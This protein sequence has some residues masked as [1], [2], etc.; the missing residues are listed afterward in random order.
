MVLWGHLVSPLAIAQAPQQPQ[1]WA[2]VNAA[3]YVPDSALS[4]GVIFALFGSSLTNGG[5]AA[6][7][8]TPLPTTLAGASVIVNGLLA[9]LFFASPGQINAQFPVELTDVAEANIEVRV[10]TAGGSSTSIPL[11]VPVEPFSPGIF[12]L[13]RNGSGPGAILR[14]NDFT[15]ICPAGRVDCTV[16]YAAAGDVIAIYLTGLGPPEGEWRS[17]EASLPSAST[18]TT[19]IVTVGGLPVPVL[20]SGLVEGLVGLYQINASVPSNV[21]LLLGVPLEVSISSYTSNAVTLST[22]PTVTPPGV[23]RGG[24]PTGGLVWDIAI[25]PSNS[26]IL[27]AATN[28]GVFKSAKG[29]VHWSPVNIGGLGNRIVMQILLDHSN[30]ATLFAA[31]NGGGV[32]KSIDAGANW[33]PSNAGL[34]NNSA[35]AF[36]ESPSS[37]GALYVATGGGVFKSTDG[38]ESWSGASTGLT[39]TNVMFL[40]ADPINSAVLYAATSG[41][42]FKTI[43]GGA[44]WIRANT[45]IT[46]SFVACVAVDPSNPS[47]VYAATA[48][49]G[50]FKTTNGGVSWSP[51]NLGLADLRLS[52]LVVDPSRPATLLAGTAEEGVFRSGDGGGS[53]SPASNGLSIDAIFTLELGRVDPG[54]VFAGTSGG[55]FRTSDGGTSWSMLN[56]GLSASATKSLAVDQD[57]PSVVIAATDG[58]GVFKSTNGGA[59]WKSINR[60][61]GR[62]SGF[63]NALAL[64]PRNV[65]I[66]YAALSNA[67]VKSVDGGSNWTVAQTGL[68]SAFLI[69]SLVVDPSN[70]DIVY[71]GFVNGRGVYRSHNGAGTWEV[72]NQGLTNLNVVSLAIHPA[73]PSI[74]YAGTR[75]GIFRSA[76]AGA[77]WSLLSTGITP[78]ALAIDPTDPARIYAATGGSGV[79]KSVDGGATWSSA[80]SGLPAVSIVSSLVIDPATPTTIYAG[81]QSVNGSNGVYK[82]TNGGEDWSLIIGGMP[83]WPVLSLA[84]DPVNPATVLAGTSG[85]GVY[86]TLDGGLLWQP[87]SPF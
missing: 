18:Q 24:G 27:Y 43:D 2:A 81:L 54:V 61:L 34:L 48:R 23:L 25:D 82:S 76:S 47:V 62:V 49:N 5:T 69:Q 45:G 32:Y 67:V 87:T 35:R 78:S 33:R 10:R 77:S 16:N 68:P 55:V 20:F 12:T 60:G 70:S 73:N 7:S 65:E 28:V 37:P 59:S 22:G 46:D 72:A 26:E 13:D 38:G 21:P 66:M 40:A 6:A 64:A 83:V 53:W 8:S 9:P 36:V 75:G 30:P 42:V 1:L 31:T 39:N 3:S 79:Y 63:V 58:G 57:D 50:A 74:V 19:P 15:A 14:G 52:S 86:R 56:N 80:R 44:T 85:G 17:G 29:G 4:P 84:L 11:L 51:I 41:G 71:A